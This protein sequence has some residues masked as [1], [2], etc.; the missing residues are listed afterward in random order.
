[1]AALIAALE[2]SSLSAVLDDVPAHACDPAV[3][4]LVV[5]D[6]NTDRTSHVARAGGGPPM[7]Q[8]AAVLPSD[9]NELATC[10]L[11]LGHP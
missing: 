6:G 1:M 4:V 5:D 9:R 7:I 2:H 10:H 8:L 11:V 3:D